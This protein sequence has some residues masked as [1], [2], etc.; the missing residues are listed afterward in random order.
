MATH[1]VCT[2]CKKKKKSEEFY[3]DIC[4]KL[5]LSSRCKACIPKRT[6]EERHLYYKK[7]CEKYRLEG[8]N[9]REVNSEKTRLKRQLDIKEDPEKVKRKN[10]EYTETYMKKYPEKYKEGGLKSSLKYYYNNHEKIKEGNLKDKELLTDA[11]IKKNIYRV[12]NISNKEQTPEMIIAYRQIMQ[13]NRTL[14]E[15]RKSCY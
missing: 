12:F 4:G 15:A 2:K 6:K 13:L 14:K 5:G 8:K 10:K 1:K 3:K 7:N 9:Y 11:Y